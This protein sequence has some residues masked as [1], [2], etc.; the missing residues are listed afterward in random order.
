VKGNSIEGVME[1]GPA[2]APW[3]ATLGG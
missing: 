2:K 1:S 3:S